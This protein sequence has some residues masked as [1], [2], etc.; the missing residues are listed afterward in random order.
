MVRIMGRMAKVFDGRIYYFD[1]QNYNKARAQGHAERLRKQGFL[2]RVV[3][4]EKG[5]WQIWKCPKR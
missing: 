3:E 4:A 2:A 1:S 5:T